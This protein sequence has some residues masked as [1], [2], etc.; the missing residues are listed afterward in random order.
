MAVG[1]GIDD[2]S[3]AMDY[4]VFITKKSIFIMWGSAK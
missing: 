3:Y 4:A 2:K 1:S